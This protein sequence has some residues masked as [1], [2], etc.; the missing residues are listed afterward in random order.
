MISTVER[1]ELDVSCNYNT[2]QYC[3]RKTY[4]IVHY[5]S[6]FIIII[7]TLY[8]SVKVGYHLTLAER[9]WNIKD[10]ANVEHV[11]FEHHIWISIVKFN[12]RINLHECQ[13][14]REAVREITHLFEE[15]SIKFEYHT[16]I[17]QSAAFKVLKLK[18]PWAISTD[19]RI[20]KKRYELLSCD[21][22]RHKRSAFIQLEF[23]A[24]SQSP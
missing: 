1:Y 22:A 3:I 10:G 11:H 24:R 15:N 13:V 20:R 4:G 19:M 5:V 16:V 18:T 8:I 9:M 2:C 7:L 12:I 6:S 21:I 23:E 14:L 17:L